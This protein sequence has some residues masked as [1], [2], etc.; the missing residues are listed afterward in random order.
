MQL[1]ASR[2]DPCHF[3]LTAHFTKTRVTEAIVII[4]V[5][6]HS[7]DCRPLHVSTLAKSLLESCFAS[8]PKVPVWLQST[9]T[10]IVLIC[11]QSML[12]V[13]GSEVPHKVLNEQLIHISFNA[14]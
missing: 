8:L 3:L 7:S 2:T 9:G 6:S 14:A 5:A 13:T 1:V 12:A 4:I 10:M 11:I